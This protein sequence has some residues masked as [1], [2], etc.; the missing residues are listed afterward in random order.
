[1][2][3]VRVGV[4]RRKSPTQRRAKGR[5][6]AGDDVVGRA[7]LISSTRQLLKK[8]PP[9]KVTRNEI[10]S[11]A[12]VN[13]AL[14]RY[15]FGDKSTLFT[16]VVEEI[17]RENIA[18]LREEFA[19]EGSATEKLRRRVQ[20]LLLM[21]I[22]NPYYH[23]LIFEQLWHGQTAEQR[24]LRRELVIPYFDEFRKLLSQGVEN[25]ELREVEPRFLHVAVIGLCE[26][27]INAPYMFR[28]LFGLK[29]I[30]SDFAS[31]YGDFVVDLLM[32]G[33]GQRAGSPEAKPTK[34]TD[35]RARKPKLD[36]GEQLVV[37]E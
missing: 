35:N 4:V 5:P 29:D 10:A 17:S 14:V 12:G 25:G 11:F 28:E 36:R 16:A 13:S 15:Y 23:Q 22:E 7:A 33:I 19:Q 20:L 8:L 24:R 21:H 31:S 6:S 2:T 1:M 34:R 30:K 3:V 9:A 37:D 26:L 18:R 32:N 27:F